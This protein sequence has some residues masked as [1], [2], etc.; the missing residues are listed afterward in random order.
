MASHFQNLSKEVQQGKLHEYFPQSQRTFAFRHNSGSDSLW[1]NFKPMIKLNEGGELEA[2]P[3]I[4]PAD[5]PVFWL[6]AD[7]DP[8]GLRRQQCQRDGR[9]KKRFPFLA[10]FG[11]I[12]TTATVFAFLPSLFLYS[13]ALCI[14]LLLLFCFL[15][16]CL[17]S[18]PLLFCLCQ[19]RCWCRPATPTKLSSCVAGLEWPVRLWVGLISPAAADECKMQWEAEVET[20]PFVCVYLSYKKQ[21]IRFQ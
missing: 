15:P 1:L 13:P 16:I 21:K 2:D 9:W 17:F 12:L 5:P 19:Q 6:P 8:P 18:Q 11:C 4:A 3:H 7:S 14:L 10:G 20:P